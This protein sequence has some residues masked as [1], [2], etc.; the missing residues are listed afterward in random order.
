M[1]TK[2][3]PRNI[4]KP[5]TLLGL[6]VTEVAI[7]SIALGI[8][9]VFFGPLMI[10]ILAVALIIVLKRVKRGKPD[11]YLQHLAHRAGLRYPGI[12]PSKKD[13]SRYAVW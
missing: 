3:C 10:I 5:L 12:L 2:T 11:G 6:E 7:I 4:D 13:G 8:T 9:Q 1:K